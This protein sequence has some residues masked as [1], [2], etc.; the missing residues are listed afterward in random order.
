[1]Y[2]L[3]AWRLGV[4][5]DGV[6]GGSKGHGL[7]SPTHTFQSLGRVLDLAR[8]EL[9]KAHAYQFW[10]K[11][12]T[13]NRVAIQATMEGLGSAKLYIGRCP[14]IACCTEVV[15]VTQSVDLVGAFMRT[16]S[17][18]TY[19]RVKPNPVLDL[20]RQIFGKQIPRQPRGTTPYFV[21]R[22]S[23]G[24]PSRGPKVPIS[25]N[26]I[27]YSAKGAWTSACKH[28]HFPFILT[29]RV[30]W[31]SWSEPKLQPRTLNPGLPMHPKLPEP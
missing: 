12:C 11:H 6:L 14:R 8:R 13:S 16:A 15:I 19:G 7:E 20:S 21:C 22:A 10:Y 30:W 5:I 3:L 9:H 31:L 26:R 2:S 24:P 23:F 29:Y 18:C 17:E 25:L 27:L 4:R 28:L 1:M